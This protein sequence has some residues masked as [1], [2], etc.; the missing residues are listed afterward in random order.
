MK[1]S[2]HKSALK[3]LFSPKQPGQNILRKA[4]VN[5][6]YPKVNT[7]NQ[8]AIADRMR[9][10]VEVARRAYIKTDSSLVCAQDRED[11]ALQPK[12]ITLKVQ[13]VLK[14]D[15]VVVEKIKPRE[16]AKVIVKK[17]EYFDPVTYGKTY[18]ADNKASLKAKRVAKY[19][20]EDTRFAILRNKQVFALNA[21]YVKGVRKSTVEKYDLKQEDDGTWF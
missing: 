10:S 13:K 8:K 11:P 1:E 2:G 19:G 4:Y 20:D 17:E 14:E 9:H 12:E 5:E 21:G 3:W 7:K 15:K 6:W 16:P 18:R